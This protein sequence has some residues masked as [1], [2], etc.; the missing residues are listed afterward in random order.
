MIGRKIMIQYRPKT[1]LNGFYIGTV[2]VLNGLE[3]LRI[4]RCRCKI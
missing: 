4:C 3:K 1:I 2:K